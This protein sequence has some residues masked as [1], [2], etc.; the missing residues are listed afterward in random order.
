MSDGASAIL[1]RKKSKSPEIVI[2]TK[3]S[4]NYFHSYIHKK[5]G[6]RIEKHSNQA[7]YIWNNLDTIDALTINMSDFDKFNFEKGKRDIPDF[8][9]SIHA[10]FDDF[11]L[12][13]I[14]QIKKSTHLAL[15]DELGLSHDKSPAYILKFGFM[16]ACSIPL[17][18]C[19]NLNVLRSGVNRFLCYSSG[20]GLSTGIIDL[21][22]NNTYI[23]ETLYTSN[24]YDSGSVDHNM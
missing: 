18:I 6:F 9:R 24:H 8:L 10:S 13:S 7:D 3:S 12:V 1:L 16:G 14:Y 19:E 22:I 21:K 23:L 2:N 20:E 11:S 5:G 17:M 15:I 4:T